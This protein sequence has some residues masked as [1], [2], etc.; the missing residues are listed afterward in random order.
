MTEFLGNYGRA[1]LSGHEAEVLSSPTYVT[2]L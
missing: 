1:N 2:Y